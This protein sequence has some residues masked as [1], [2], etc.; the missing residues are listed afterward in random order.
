MWYAFGSLIYGTPKGTGNIK[1]YFDSLY[2]ICKQYRSI[3]HVGVFLIKS[4]F[5]NNNKQKQPPKKW[6]KERQDNKMYTIIYPVFKK[7]K[8]IVMFHSECDF[9]KCISIHFTIQKSVH[10][11]FTN[12][13]SQCIWYLIIHLKL[14]CCISTQAFDLGMYGPN[15]V[16]ILTGYVSSS[17]QSSP[18]GVHCSSEELRIASEGYFKVGFIMYGLSQDVGRCGKVEVIVNFETISN[19]FKHVY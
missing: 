17:W 4:N 11:Y 2:R 6:H 18:E 9:L 10:G 7:Q 15:Y 1:Q 14:Y 13:W 19:S 16:W 12:K 5:E 8:Q 3:H